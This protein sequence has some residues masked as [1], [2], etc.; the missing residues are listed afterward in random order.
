MGVRLLWKSGEST[1]HKFLSA[2]APA[3]TW[4]HGEFLTGSKY[5]A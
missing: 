4:L 5:S 1:V 2:I 3:Y